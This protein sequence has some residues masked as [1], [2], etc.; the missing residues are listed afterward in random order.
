[1]LRGQENLGIQGE[2]W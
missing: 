2:I 1:M